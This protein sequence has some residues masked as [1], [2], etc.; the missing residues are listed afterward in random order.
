MAAALVCG[1]LACSC[2]DGHEEFWISA[3]GSGRAE[4]HY[5]VP[6][7]A[8]ALQGGKEGIREILGHLL[9]AN[10]RVF[11]EASHDVHSENGVLHIRLRVAFASAEDLS[12]LE[13]PKGKIPLPVRHFAGQFELFQDGR[14][15]ELRRTVAP[16]KGLPG[17]AF[18]PASQFKNKRLVYIIHLPAPALESNATRV[19]NDGRTLVWD[20]PLTA[21]LREPLV[22]N[23][24]IEAPLPRWIFGV[25]AAAA[26]LLG[27]LVVAVVRRRTRRTGGGASNER[28]TDRDPFGLPD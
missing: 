20:H 28:I 6:S 27:G 1:L 17:H 19:E 5:Q 24:T 14:L 7:A 26:L 13:F 15:I 3:D 10:E 16:G 23:V 11:T 22:V 4:V 8:A 18:M 21:Q 12:K 25:A 2:I 9:L